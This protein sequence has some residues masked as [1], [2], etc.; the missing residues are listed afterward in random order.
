MH[1]ILLPTLSAFYTDHLG[2]LQAVTK[3]PKCS[4]RLGTTCL[5]ISGFQTNAD[6]P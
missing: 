1:N 6:V 4:S 5:N 2:L 3:Q